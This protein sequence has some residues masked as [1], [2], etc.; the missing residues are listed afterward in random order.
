MPNLE[1]LLNHSSNELT[2]VQN[3]PLWISKIDR[4]YAYGQIKLAEETSRQCNFVKFGG[5]MNGYKKFKKRF[6]GQ[7][8]IPTKFEEKI[9]RILKH[10]TPV[11]LDDIIIVTRGIKENTEKN[12][13]RLEKIQEAGYKASEKKSE[14][15]PKKQLGWD[16]R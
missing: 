6:H 8:D 14:I 2:R 16:T 7:S 9:D 12:F 15:S 11:W 1:E 13:T 10:Q 4:K 3:E 5:I